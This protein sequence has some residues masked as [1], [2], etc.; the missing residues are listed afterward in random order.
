MEILIIGLLTLLNGFFSL[1][2][3]ALVSVKES[4]IQ[5]LADQ[6]STRAKTILKLL[7]NPENFLS[8]VQVGITLIGI[9]AGAY[10]GATLTDDMVAALGRWPALAPYTKDIALVIVIGGITYFTIVVGE[11][12]PK[13]IAMNDPERIALFTA[14][15]IKIFTNITYPLVKLLSVS[16]ALIVKILPIK[17][18]TEAKLS[19]EELRAIIRTANLEGVLDKQES[20][21]HQ[22]LFRFS[23]HVAKTLMTHR[24]D[25]EWI[26]ST[27]PLDAIIAQVKASYHSKFPV[28][29]GNIDDVMGTLSIR[30]LLDEMNKPGFKL[31]DVVRPPIYVPQSAPAFTILGR[32]KKNKQYA[33]L[34][35]DEHGQLKGMV[36]LHDLIEAIMGDL[37]DEDEDSAPEIV[38]RADGSWLV[39][40]QVL[41]GDLNQHL[42]RNLI[43]ENTAAYATIGGY[44]LSKL[45]R[46]PVAGDTIQDEHFMGEVMDMD[47]NRIDKV[48]LTLTE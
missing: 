46:L 47:G 32:F 17:E 35:I 33:A 37:P 48:L 45:E 28:C 38:K 11:L 2:E 39:G 44:F 31:G 25:L 19:E 41:I 14:P 27:Q 9:I 36:T 30:D 15:I 23:D 40:G 1:S 24:N 4:R 18:S 16:T 22:N 34:V 10:G 20:E 6:G 29:R 42:G 21:A 5:A 12:V 3:I 26:D 13:S 43:E 7:A 8:S